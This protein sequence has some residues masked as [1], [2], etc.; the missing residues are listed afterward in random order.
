MFYDIS[1]CIKKIK[2]KRQF[3]SILPF[4]WIAYVLSYLTWK[5]RAR[6]SF[7]FIR[8]V[9]LCWRREPIKLIMSASQHF[10]GEH[11]CERPGVMRSELVYLPPPP[12]LWPIQSTSQ[13]YVCPCLS[14]HMSHVPLC[15]S[16][17][18]VHRGKRHNA[19]QNFWPIENVCFLYSQLCEDKAYKRP[20]LQ[21]CFVFLI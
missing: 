12:F 3:P 1:T 7:F 13:P 17:S 5:L 10:R 6:K 20:S 4:I 9:T 18:N 16:R 11:W 8:F 15:F 2:I 21:S 14:D 19:F